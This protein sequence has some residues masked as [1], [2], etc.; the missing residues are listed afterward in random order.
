MKNLLPIAA[1]LCCLAVSANAQ[2]APR[3][4]DNFDTS[5][6]VQVFLP[7]PPPAAVA[8]A[9]RKKKNGKWVVA[10]EDKLVKKTGQSK[11]VVSVTDSL[12]LREG[13]AGAGNPRLTMGTGSQ[14]KGFTTG[15]M[16][17]DS[18]ILDSSRR[19]NIDPLLIY[20]QMHQE[21]TFKLRA[22][23]PKGASG[24]MQLMPGTARRFG[25]DR[26]YDPKQ[27]I[28]GGVRYMRWLLDT[29]NGDVV[30]ALAGYNAGEGAV[31]KYGWQVPPY[32]ETQEYVRRITDRY[33][34]ISDPRY[35]QTAR[36][37][38]SSQAARLEQKVSRPL[39]VYEPDP[40]AV[41]LPNGN[42][43]LVNQ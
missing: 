27:N 4:Y 22:T 24:L 26:I 25:V 28:E 41:R 2:T 15:D 17:I 33:N 38:S 39:T 8:T 20:S 10:V 34:A 32:R 9:M 31:M 29:F 36:R 11:W 7:P 3:V 30:L 13:A 1:V 12:A 43:M 23:S 42:T 40:V 5:R 18:Y 14:L 19:Y 6:G 37:V 21:S 35:V 16:L